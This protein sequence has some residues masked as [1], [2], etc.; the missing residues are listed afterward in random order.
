MYFPK[1]LMKHELFIHSEEISF[2]CVD[3]CFSVG[4]DLQVDFFK[5]NH[6]VLG[7]NELSVEVIFAHDSEQ[8]LNSEIREF[9]SE[10]YF[11]IAIAALITVEWG[12]YNFSEE[13]YFGEEEGGF[14]ILI[15]IGAN[16]FDNSGWID[17][18]LR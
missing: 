7:F 6:T 14:A 2:N 3:F 12:D 4:W 15:A 5:M 18:Y 9:S 8:N 11:V 16:A 1:R 10:L 13:R 17:F